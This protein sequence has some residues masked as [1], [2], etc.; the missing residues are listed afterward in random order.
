M[1]D[2]F[3]S[4]DSDQCQFSLLSSLEC[5]SFVSDHTDAIIH[6]SAKLPTLYRR[7]MRNCIRVALWQFACRFHTSS[8]LIIVPR[9]RSPSQWNLSPWLRF[10]SL[11]RECHEFG[12]DLVEI[13]QS[14]AVTPTSLW[15]SMAGCEGQRDRMRTGDWIEVR[16]EDQGP[17]NDAGLI[18]TLGM[19]PEVT[20]V[21]SF[22]SRL[23][24]PSSSSTWSL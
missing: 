13:W 4:L 20:Q 24:S 16:A 18:M 14:L 21:A 3:S 9:Q 5:E 23:Q 19:T 1:I 15:L 22:S 6:F 7:V 10:Q 12:R 11:W 17:W 2:C 8:L